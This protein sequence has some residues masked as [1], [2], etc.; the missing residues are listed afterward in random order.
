MYVLIRNANGEALAASKM[1]EPGFQERNNLVW[2]VEKFKTGPIWMCIWKKHIVSPRI[3]GDLIKHVVWYTVE[4]ISQ[5]QYES[6]LEMEL[7]ENWAWDW[8]QQFVGSSAYARE[9]RAR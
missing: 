2:R 7:I 6:Y 1:F 8:L 9:M 3:G 5:A 4:K